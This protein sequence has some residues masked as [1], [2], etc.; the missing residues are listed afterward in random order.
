[1]KTLDMVD[2]ARTRMTAAEFLA[3]PESMTPVELLDG[4]MVMSPTPIPLHQRLVL[5]FANL[6]QRTAKTGEVFIVPLDVYFDDENLA[7]PDVFFIA[8][9]S[10]CVVGEKYVIGAPDLVIEVFSPSTARRDRK[11]KIALYERFGVREYWMADPDGQYVEAWRLAEGK[12]ARVGV[13]GEGET[14]E[15]A[16]LGAAEL[17]GVFG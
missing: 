2:A 14:F 4:E 12:F 7:Q 11:E 8:A 3:L 16:L 9:G 17:K 10:A 15:S 1:M 6:V 5:R 13:F